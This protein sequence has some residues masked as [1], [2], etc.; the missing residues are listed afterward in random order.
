MES[1]TKMITE[2]KTEKRNKK[3]NSDRRHSKETTAI[4]M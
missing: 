4:E 3:K 1:N 2:G